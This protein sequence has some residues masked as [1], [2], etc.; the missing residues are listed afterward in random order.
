MQTP[1]AERALSLPQIRSLLRSQ[2]P[3]F[4]EGS[5]HYLSEGWDNIL[6]RLG[7]EHLLRLP[8]REVAVQLLLNEQQ[9][10]PQLAIHLPISVPVPIHCGRPT[11]LFPW[12]WSISPAF[13][14]EVAAV[15]APGPGE[16]VRLAQFFRSL[17]QI[18]PSDAPKN[19]SRGGQLSAK[20]PTTEARLHRL[21][22][23]ENLPSALLDI[24]QDA[25]AAPLHTGPARWL[26]GDP[27]PKNMLVHQGTFSAIIDWGDLTAGDVANDLA[28]FWMLFADRAIRKHALS[29]YGVDEATY[30]RARGW[31]IFFGAI[32]L[33]VGWQA[34]D[35]L[36]VKVGQRTLYHVVQ[37]I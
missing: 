32:L 12:P 7:D 35:P 13:P 2:A 11:E 26:H 5:I 30:R 37:E 3:E 1:P 9:W 4:A 15:Q 19:A 20:V 17:H 16:A 23:R 34:S 8:R 31:A 14:G 10:L 33:E 22:Q 21:Q 25:L 24:W 18:A 27:H 29:T 36:F 6:Y 28:A